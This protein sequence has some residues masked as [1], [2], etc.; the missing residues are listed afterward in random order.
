MYKIVHVLIFL[1]FFIVFSI[2]ISISISFFLYLHRG[3]PHPPT[4]F[5]R[6]PY[7][8]PYRG[9]DDADDA[10]VDYGRFHN[11]GVVSAI[12]EL[13]AQIPAGPPGYQY[14]EPNYRKP[15][16]E[17][18]MTSTIASCHLFATSPLF[19]SPE[20]IHHRKDR[21]RPPPPRPTSPSNVINPSDYTFFA[22]PPQVI[23]LHVFNSN[24]KRFYD[25]GA[26]QISGKLQQYFYVVSNF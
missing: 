15:I 13:T 25:Y 22:Q 6:D 3:F 4:S 17:L 19:S 14:Q 5:G 12:D 26:F 8:H 24:T 1:Y 10:G 20:S 11:P 21:T 2:S 7:Q 9:E 23:T 16:R 18:M